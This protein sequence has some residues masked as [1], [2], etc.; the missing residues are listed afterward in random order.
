[1]RTPPSGWGK[2][3]QAAS[4]VSIY[5]EG[6]ARNAENPMEWIY[7]REAVGDKFKSIAPLFFGAIGFTAAGWVLAIRD[8]NAEKPVKDAELARDLTV[9]RVAVPDGQMKEEQRKQKRIFRAGWF[10]F[11]LC[12]VPV[13][14]YLSNGGH[15]PDGNLEKMIASLALH[16]FPW[17]I[18][19]LGCLMVS[20]VLQE[21]SILRETEAARL[22]IK[23]E[24]ASDI[25]PEP[26]ADGDRKDLKAK[27]V[28]Q[29][30][31]V[32]AAVVFL[33]LGVCNGS[34]KAV[35]TKAA[36]ICTECVGLG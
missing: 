23:E 25:K 6:R 26:K 13:G 20:A 16:I 7:P 17:I 36:N 9:S 34:A 28:L 10:C 30:V 8:E 19:G 35:Y 4:A 12:M 29:L 5:R 21:K 33:I 18:L 24:N 32:A 2:A 14:I 22:R 3:V 31:V 11:L 27:S 1:M 15:F